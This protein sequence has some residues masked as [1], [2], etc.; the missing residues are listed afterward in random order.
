MNEIIKSKNINIVKHAISAILIFKRPRA[1]RIRSE[2]SFAFNTPPCN[3][4]AFC[5]RHRKVLSCAAVPSTD[6][7][8]ANGDQLSTRNATGMCA[9]S[10][11][12]CRIQKNV[13]DHT[14]IHILK[15]TCVQTKAHT[16]LSRMVF[17]QLLMWCREW[18]YTR[19][20]NKEFHTRSDFLE[21][22]MLQKS[23]SEFSCFQFV[24][25][26]SDQVQTKIIQDLPK[27]LPRNKDMDFI[28]QWGRKIFL[29]PSKPEE[30]N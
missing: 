13:T 20:S 2:E 30:D 25:T 12:H 11:V 24:L 4:P 14:P 8:P 3:E 19:C 21:R 7:T 22:V 15:L 6:D 29:L 10:Y 18:I 1:A 26:W 28:V 27:L 17:C 5:E 23:D 9:F 16:K